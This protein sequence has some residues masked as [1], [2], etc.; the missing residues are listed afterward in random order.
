MPVGTNLQLIDEDCN[1]DPCPQQPLEP[2]VSSSE[3]NTGRRYPV[4]QRRAPA[5]LNDYVL[6]SIQDVCFKEG[7]GVREEAMD[8]TI[9]N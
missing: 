2:A 6:S 1:D 8:R 5:R 7:G 9:D 4:R 3:P